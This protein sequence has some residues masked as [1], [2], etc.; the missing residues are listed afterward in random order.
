MRA[1]VGTLVDL[2]TLAVISAY[3][4]SDT[5]TAHW[6]LLHAALPFRLGDQACGEGLASGTPAQLTG[7]VAGSVRAK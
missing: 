1:S 4:G 6:R 2:A 3:P 7:R 5:T